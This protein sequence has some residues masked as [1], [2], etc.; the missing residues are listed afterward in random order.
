M[1][2]QGNQRGGAKD[3]AL[4]LLKDENEHVEVH[5]I[6]G[7]VSDDLVGALNEA[8]Y[9]SKGTRAKQFLFSLS[10]NP[11]QNEKVSIESFENAISRVEDKLGLTGQPRAIVFHE[12][13]GRRHCHAVWSRTDS[14]A[15]K[16]IPLPHTKR[17]LMEISREL[18][19][20]HGWDIPSGMVKSEE[21]DPRNFTLA[22]WQQ[23]K[24]IGKDPKTIKQDFQDCWAM[25]DNRASFEHALKSRGYILAKGDRRGFVALDYRCEVFAVPKWVD[26]K[27]KDVRAKLG[28]SNELPSVIDA[29]TQIAKDMGEQLSKL[30]E[31]QGNAVKS[32]IGTIEKARADLTTQHEFD[33]Q[34]LSERHEARWTEETT[35]RQS[36]YRK[37]VLGIW[38]RITG[39]HKNIRKQNELEASSSLLRDR[40]EKD[41]LIF[42]QLQERQH[43]QKRLD[44]LQNFIDRKSTDISE[45]IERYRDI[46]SQKREIFE[47]RKSRNYKL[48]TPNLKM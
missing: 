47:I 32:R 7:F 42:E 34:L 13:Y 39:K 44:L 37:G 10:L 2:L 5:E 6:S 19:I 25:S 38:D 27:A 1:I 22:Q 23:A 8:Y 18:F 31:Q 21:R 3:L 28:D 20:E 15:M 41:N 33:R 43:L 48:R 24:R 29:K 36:R 9:V 46:Q 4:H 40:Q 12:K 17:K 14:K 35:I 45:D 30:R 26:I 16:A 11:P